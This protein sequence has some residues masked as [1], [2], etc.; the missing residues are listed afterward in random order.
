MLEPWIKC[1][2]EGKV[3]FLPFVV[4]PLIF[5]F[6]SDFA[7]AFVYVFVLVFRTLFRLS[8]SEQSV[9]FPFYDGF[10]TIIWVA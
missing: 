8:G 9:Q 5:C 7:Q 6:T 10:F 2:D 1:G 3:D 4:I